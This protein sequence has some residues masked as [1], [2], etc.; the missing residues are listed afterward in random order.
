MLNHNL[1]HHLLP[2]ALLVAG[3]LTLTGCTNNDYDLNNVDATMG[4]GSESLVI[5]N[6]STKDIQ[7]KDV[8]DLKE[9]G[10][11]VTCCRQLPV[12]AGWRRCRGSLSKHFAYHPR[13]YQRVRWRYF[14][15]QRSFYGCQGKTRSRQQPP[16]CFTQGHDVRISWQR[17]GCKKS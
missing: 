17:Q 14:T 9:G 7:L 5:P 16:S 11:V 15:E 3:F 13:R 8:L 4:F 1:K 2:S 12:P 6:S 10:C